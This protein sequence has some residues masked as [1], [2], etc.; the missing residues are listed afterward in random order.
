M[1]I[2]PPSYLPTTPP[3]QLACSVY[4][5]TME[6]ACHPL[7]FKRQQ[8][9]ANEEEFLKHSTSLYLVSFDRFHFHC[10]TDITSL[11]TLNKCCWDQELTAGT[12]RQRH[13]HQQIKGQ[14]S[15]YTHTPHSTCAMQTPLCLLNSKILILKLF[16]TFLPA[17]LP[18]LPLCPPPH[19]SMACQC[20]LSMVFPIL[21]LI[22]WVLTVSNLAQRSCDWHFQLLLIVALFLKMLVHV[23]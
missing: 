1:L 16:Q 3:C 9:I 8:N 21:C 7:H 2:I 12:H 18:C 13:Y 6:R 20:P 5:M 11:C 4:N 19:L 10:P 23:S 17:C 22:H 14:R 15:H